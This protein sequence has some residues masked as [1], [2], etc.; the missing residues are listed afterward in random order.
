MSISSCRQGDH[1]TAIRPKGRR[2]VTLAVAVLRPVQILALTPR[3]HNRCAHT[4]A[5]Y[6][7]PPFFP[8]DHSRATPNLLQQTVRT[9]LLPVVTAR[10]PHV[11][12]THLLLQ[13]ATYKRSG[14]L[15][16]LASCISLCQESP[17]QKATTTLP[18]Y[19]SHCVFCAWQ[20]WSVAMSA[21]KMVPEASSMQP[22]FVQL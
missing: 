1:H 18:L 22:G 11:L 2:A 4:H 19:D 6:S 10:P 20:E 16:S 9:S 13:E 7:S 14:R 21:K 5:R 3:R 8:S 15:L 12:T 17:M